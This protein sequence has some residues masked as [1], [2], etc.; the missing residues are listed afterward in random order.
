MTLC[1]DYA[2]HTTIEVWWLLQLHRP[3]HWTT[4]KTIDIKL[5]KVF[6]I[7]NCFNSI[8]IKI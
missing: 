6:K 1:D 3:A 7:E 2:R 4:F 5:N 8:K